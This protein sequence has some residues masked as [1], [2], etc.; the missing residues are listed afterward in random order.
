[1]QQKGKA[2]DS[3]WLRPTAVKI[4]LLSGYPK[5]P[6]LSIFRLFWI[7]YAPGLPF[8]ICSPEPGTSLLLVLVLINQQRA[9]GGGT[10]WTNGL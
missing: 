1:M 7:L 4:H 8:A 5:S 2:A 10:G 9:S 3:A 6:F